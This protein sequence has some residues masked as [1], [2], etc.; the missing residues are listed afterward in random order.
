M[1]GGVFCM[2]RQR[3]VPPGPNV[4]SSHR[5]TCRWARRLN[6]L[7]PGIVS[8][9]TGLLQKGAPVLINIFM[10]NIVHVVTVDG[11]CGREY[12]LVIAALWNSTRLSG[13]HISTVCIVAEKITYP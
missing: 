13:T 7:L 10:T 4:W 6:K 11:N 3:R 5:S 8:I 9:S 1:E 2:C 12:C